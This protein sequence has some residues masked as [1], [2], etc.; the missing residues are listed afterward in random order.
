MKKNEEEKQ[1]LQ[2]FQFLT[3]RHNNRIYEGKNGETYKRIRQNYGVVLYLESVT[4]RDYLFILLHL[5][6]P[7]L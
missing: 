3:Y 5:L 1:G 6:A 4:I 7:F 2:E